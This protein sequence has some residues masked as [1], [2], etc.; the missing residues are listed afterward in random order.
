MISARHAESIIN[1]RTC[2]V[3][4]VHLFGN[5]CDVDGLSALARKHKTHLLFDAAHAFNCTMGTTHVGN[6]GDAEVLSFHATKCFSTFEGGAVLTN[7]EE[8]AR[9]LRFNR[10]FGF[11]TY[12]TVDQLGI[13][14]KM[15]E[16]CAAMGL[17][18]LEEVEDRREKLNRTY[19]LYREA[20]SG[21]DGIRLLPVGERG[22]SNYHYIVVLADETFGVSRDAV[23]K[24]LWKE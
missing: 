18:S 20:L 6:F 22:K 15:P 11:S 5:I 19:E 21:L 17:A 14:G 23:C 10:N 1:D 9:R 13:N 8:L 12:D 2:A 7:D 3:I 4:G 24:V 16:A